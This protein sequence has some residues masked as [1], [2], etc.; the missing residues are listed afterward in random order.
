M[1]ATQ[2]DQEAAGPFRCADA[3]LLRAA[4]PPSTLPESTERAAS[5]G[6]QCVRAAAADPYLREAL[7]LSSASL[8]LTMEKAVDGQ[9]ISPRQLRRAVRAVNRYRLRMSSRATPFGI[10]AGVAEG[11]FGQKP[12]AQWGAAHRKSVLP[13]SRW[14]S[15]VIT[16]W[17]SDLDVLRMLRVTTNDLCVVRGGRLVVPHTPGAEG[18]A[19]KRLSLRYTAAL[20]VTLTAAERPVRFTDLQESLT[21]RFPSVTEATVVRLLKQLVG[22]GVL[23]TE[24]RPGLASPD[25]LGHVLARLSA[26]LDPEHPATSRRVRE[27]AAVRSELAEY[28]GTPLG[29]GHRSLKSVISRMN[30]MRT[31]VKPVQADLG[32]DVEFTL[33]R[34]VADEVERTVEVLG[35]LARRRPSRTHLADY[36]AVF[37]ERYGTQRAVPLLELVDPD[38]GIGS[39][40]G[41]TQ[42]RTAAREALARPP[43][44]HSDDVLVSLAQEASLNGEHEVVLDEPLVRRLAGDAQETAATSTLQSFDLL[45]HVLADSL[46]ALENGDFR[47]VLLAA[48]SQAGSYAG[49]FAGLRPNGTDRYARLLRDLPARQT[50]AELVELLFTPVPPGAANVA[51][52]RSWAATRIE[53]GTFADRGAHDVLGLG[54]IAVVATTRRLAA[55]SLKRGREIEPTL[56]SMVSTEAHAPNAVRLLG[57]ITRSGDESLPVWNWGAAQ[58]L[59]FLPRVRHGRTVVSPARW[60]PAPALLGDGA[61]PAEVWAADFERWRERWRVPGRVRL[62]DGDHRITLDLSLPA[63]LELLRDELRRHPSAVLEELPD[64]GDRGLGWL[65]PTDGDVRRM[66][67]AAEVVFSLMRRPATAPAPTPASPSSRSR[68]AGH[69]ASPPTDSPVPFLHLAEREVHLPGSKWLYAKV[70]CAAER[71]DEILADRLP[72]FLAEMPCEVRRWFYVRYH[73][74][75]PHLRL[76]FHGEPEVLTGALL[77]RLT[78]WVRDLSDTGPPH[79]LVLDTYDPE[80][81]RYGG[82]A[83]MS[84]AEAFFEADSR[85]CLEQIRLLRDSRSNL[86]PTVMVAADFM[87]IAHRV[88]G[89]EQAQHWLSE[90]APRMYGVDLR[91]TRPEDVLDPR[92]DWSGLRDTP[93]GDRLWKSWS[94]RAPSL[95]QFTDRLR[96]REA[97]GGGHAALS[98]VLASLIHMHHNRVHG[99]D[100]EHEKQALALAAAAAQAHLATAR[101]AGGERNRTK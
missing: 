6:V 86:D 48:K 82:L 36:H 61:P 43:A 101:H 71:Q 15:E 39:P 81:E 3:L 85:A 5:D 22:M 68:G 12:Q 92:D 99:T 52:T 100:Q 84:A 40:A 20:R 7:L 34:G 51:R 45:T 62:A 42:P 77:P 97:G 11:A 21:A 63:H 47:I 79:R 18:T 37:L 23:L 53:A 73:D 55:L 29:Q 96:T 75:A 19:L 56:V 2:E 76:R 94:E 14:L 64:S 44:P 70:Y 24:L 59:P 98:P 13:D 60:R 35:R 32:L 10:L 69:G 57:E 58:G 41:Y 16:E 31:S 46:S 74:D 66:G 26:R 83:G 38:T 90:T 95:A 65:A 87:D 88:L 25:P 72:A 49:R 17:E 4:V 54:D 33:P 9:A 1:K 89:P 67:H 80:T 91:G 93:G 8:S 28:A 30:G 50:D 78:A 27:L